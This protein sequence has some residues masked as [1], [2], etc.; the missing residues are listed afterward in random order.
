M[1]HR[2]STIFLRKL[3][4]VARS[5]SGFLLAKLTAWAHLVSGVIGGGLVLL[6]WI[7]LPGAAVGP[8]A[9]V[10]LDLAA[11]VSAAALSSSGYYLQSAT[12]IVIPEPKIES[13]AIDFLAA[14]LNVAAFAVAVSMAKQGRPVGM[15]LGVMLI[16]GLWSLHNV[17]ITN[18]AGRSAKAPE[19]KRGAEAI[20]QFK[21]ENAP[22][23]FCYAAIPLLLLVIHGHAPTETDGLA[24]AAF[25]GG[26]TGFHLFLSSLRYSFSAKTKGA[27]EHLEEMGECGKTKLE[28]M[29]KLDGGTIF[30]AWSVILTCIIQWW[31]Y[32]E[33]WGLTW[34]A[35]FL[36]G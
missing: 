32:L 8:V 36:K 27:L 25:V 11:L 31:V 30:F 10:R 9:Y 21:V 1:S 20:T 34:E 4:D 6:A 17:V 15:C 22:T 18:L 7:G 5:V 28:E 26:A 33:G 3:S 24:F 2:Q 35:Q 29:S 23:F 19:L 14:L 13:R 16:Y 12:I